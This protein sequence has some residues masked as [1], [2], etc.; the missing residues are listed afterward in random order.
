MMITC[1]VSDMF[2]LCK[3]KSTCVDVKKGHDMLLHEICYRV[4]LNLKAYEEGQLDK[5]KRFL[6]GD[7]IQSRM[8]ILTI[9]SK[10]R[11]LVKV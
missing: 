11:M 6:S 10:L 7:M 3:C 2:Y 9:E 4:V 1:N 8:K 5:A